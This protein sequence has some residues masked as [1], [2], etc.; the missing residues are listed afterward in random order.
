M[1]ESNDASAETGGCCNPTSN[2]GHGAPKVLFPMDDGTASAAPGGVCLPDAADACTDDVCCGPPPGPASSTDEKPGYRICPFVASFLETPAGPVPRV[3][4]RA[5]LRDRLGTAGARIGFIRGR[6]RVAPGLYA[7]GNPDADAPV[8]ATANYKLSFDALRTQLKGVDA[9]IL[10]LD[11]RGV[12]VWC[13]AGKA[14]FSTEELVRRVTASGLARVVRHRRLI[15]PQLAATGVA[16][17]RVKQACGFRIVWGPVRAG[18]IPA[19]L[20]A[21]GVATEAMRTVTFTLT[22][23]LVLVPVELAGAVKPALWALAAAFVLSGI[24]P[25]VFS[26][27]RA[28]QR[29]GVLALAALLGLIAGAVVAPALLPWLPTRW[30]AVKGLCTSVPAGLLAV[31][32]GSG[33][34]GSPW[35][36]A[37]GML[38]VAAAVGSF[39]AMNF[40]G[41]TPYTSPSGVE[42]EMRKAIPLQAAGLVVGVGM[43][44][45]AAF[46]G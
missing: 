15:L 3:R 20:D 32:A 30:F 4:T 24:G 10:V 12:N 35:L 46:A 7:V 33:T 17:R 5:D 37:L 18:D 6:Y 11:T 1:T 36:N 38:A 9:W 23:R 26:V 16:A 13:A 39:M 22:E 34:P 29:G 42:K 41:S 43:W 21:G 45:W 31:W 8:L 19:F 28:W 27:Y 25:G 40:T 44:L 2:S 14:L